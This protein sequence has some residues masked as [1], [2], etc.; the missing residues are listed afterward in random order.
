MRNTE[1]AFLWIMDILERNKITYKISGGFAART[2]GVKRELA[3]ID[4]EV[5]DKDISIIASETK[6]YIKFGPARYKDDNWDLELCTLVYEDQ[7][8]DI[9]GAEAKI[10]NQE[11]KEW[12]NSFSNLSNVNLVNVYGKT[13]RVE[14]LNSLVSYKSKLAR[15]VDLEDVKQ[16]LK[17]GNKE[18]EK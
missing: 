17:I 10:F 7:E 6:P 18:V 5:S 12:E 11:T 1:K 14:T 16:L 15:D 2:Y 3:D 4:I 8:I 13:V 9:A